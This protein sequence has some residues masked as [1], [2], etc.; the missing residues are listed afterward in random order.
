MSMKK[1][2][3]GNYGPPGHVDHTDSGPAARRQ[4]ARLEI[5]RAREERIR[6]L[7]RL[8]QW[9]EKRYRL[10]AEQPENRDNIAL[11]TR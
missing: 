4:R 9:H 5:R 8:A 11:W 10:A 7:N 1:Q 3:F 6:N 2:I